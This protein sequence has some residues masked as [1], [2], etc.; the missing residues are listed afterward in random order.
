MTAKELI[1]LLSEVDENTPVFIPG[2]EDTFNSVDVL[3]PISVIPNLQK[4]STRLGIFPYGGQ[5]LKFPKDED[6]AYDYNVS[7]VIKGIVLS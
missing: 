1:Q 3:D 2:E 4:G 7:E 5:Y 6:N